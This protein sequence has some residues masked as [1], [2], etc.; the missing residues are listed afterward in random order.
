M[1]PMQSF[2]FLSYF[3]AS[4]F[5]GSIPFAAFIA[6]LKNVDLRNVGS[7]NMGATNV[8]RTL[9]WKFGILV[10]IL[11]GAKGY[12][13]VWLSIYY[14]DNPWVHICVGAAS[15]L[16]HS[17]SP[18]LK[19]KGG[20]GAATTAGILFALS[21]DVFGILLMIGSILTIA[22]RYVAVV[23]ITCSILAPILLYLFHY[24]EAYIGVVSLISFFIIFRHRSNIVRLFHKKE[25]KI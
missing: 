4:F 16:G 9:G 11:D 1:K 25:N 15:V 20:K 22:L 14:S 12:F 3:I 7:G 23:S 5:I 21:P 13:P 10:L 8:Y 17:F 18:F 2:S 19:F 24:S 6:K